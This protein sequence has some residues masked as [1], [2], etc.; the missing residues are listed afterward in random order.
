MIEKIS[1]LNSE[2][3]G[4]LGI[5]FGSISG[6]IIAII[7][8]KKRILPLL[9]QKENPINLKHHDIFSTLK[10]VEKEIG[11]MKFYTDK[12]FD[13][14]K[15]AMCYDFARYKV[16]YCGDLM[17]EMLENEDLD[18]MKKDR[19]KS[20]IIQSQ[21]DMHNNYIRE[22]RKY[23]LAKNI[24]EEDI[25][26]VVKIFDTFR[27]DVIKSFDQRITSILVYYLQFLICGLWE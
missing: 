12:K 17:L 5:V 19:L 3:L 18:K 10:R 2:L 26:Y 11:S 13:K 6:I 24:K 27:Y 25:D 20:Y 1:S 9:S 15:T 7:N 16:K 22:I 23:W 14:V 21:M 4:F 8:T